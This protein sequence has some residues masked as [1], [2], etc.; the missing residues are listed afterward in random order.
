MRQ[1]KQWLL[2][3]EKVKDFLCHDDTTDNIHFVETIGLYMICDIYGDMAVGDGKYL[4]GAL[5]PDRQSTYFVLKEQ[6]MRLL[7]LYVPQ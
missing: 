5:H 7:F 3:L 2:V 6:L 4:W 1:M